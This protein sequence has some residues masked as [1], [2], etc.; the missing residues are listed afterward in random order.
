MRRVRLN[1]Y[2]EQTF[3][4]C[5]VLS[6][7][8]QFGFF[9]C[10]LPLPLCCCRQ[11]EHAEQG[12]QQ[13]VGQFLESVVGECSHSIRTVVQGNQASPFHA[14]INEPVCTFALIFN[15]I[16]KFS[17]VPEL[18]HEHRAS[19]LGYEVINLARYSFRV[20]RVLRRIKDKH[21]FVDCHRKKSFQ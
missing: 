14:E 10:L 1:Q 13:A 8:L 2:S 19:M 15:W 3:S 11:P 4:F 17:F 6:R 20:A 9:T 16:G 5:Q 21:P 7:C 18:G 12:V